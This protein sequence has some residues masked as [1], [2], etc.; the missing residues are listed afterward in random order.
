[1]SLVRFLGHS[2]N[3]VRQVE[4]RRHVVQA[5]IPHQISPKGL[6]PMERCNVRPGREC[7]PVSLWGRVLSGCC[8]PSDVHAD[9]DL[10]QD[11]CSRQGTYRGPRLCGLLWTP[12]DVHA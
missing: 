9:I 5:A 8:V 3:V 2:L 6:Y 4:K 7:V 11:T 12:R 10:P 1:M